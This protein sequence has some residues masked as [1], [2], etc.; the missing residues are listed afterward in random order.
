MFRF[1]LEIA[2]EVQMDRGIARFADGVA[3][4]RPIW[5]VIEDDFYALEQDQFKSQ[6][7]EGGQPL[8]P[9]LP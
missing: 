6:G 3:D 9:A 5:S 1:R 2:G 7:A 4:Y 8:G